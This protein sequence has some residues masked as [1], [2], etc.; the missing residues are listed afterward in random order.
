M[1]R[2]KIRLLDAVAGSDFSYPP[3]SFQFVDA[4]QARGWEQQGTCSIIPDADLTA[5]DRAE[6]ARDPGERQRVGPKKND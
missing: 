4:E 1:K 6:L 3:G 5:A 2:L